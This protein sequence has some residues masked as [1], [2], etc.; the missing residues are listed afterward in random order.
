MADSVIYAL[1]MI[2]F[3]AG[4]GLLA[5]LPATVTTDQRN[6]LMIILVIFFVACFAYILKNK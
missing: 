3:I 1:L 6:I 2:L 5:S 4:F